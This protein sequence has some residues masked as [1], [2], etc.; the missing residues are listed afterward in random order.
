MRCNKKYLYVAHSYKLGMRIAN[1][2]IIDQC[3][4]AKCQM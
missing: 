4:N 3:M 1:F 2:E